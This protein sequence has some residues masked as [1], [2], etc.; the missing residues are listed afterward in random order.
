MML[1]NINKM[2]KNKGIARNSS[3]LLGPKYWKKLDNKWKN[4]AESS[5]KSEQTNV[6]AQLAP[7]ANMG[8]VL[9]EAYSKSNGQTQLKKPRKVNKKIT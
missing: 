9:R 1:S 4:E 3:K 6:M 5:G 8:N 2:R 7:Y